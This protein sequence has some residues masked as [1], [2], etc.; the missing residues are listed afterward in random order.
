MDDAEAY[1]RHRSFP[2]HVADL[3]CTP[4]HTPLS[5]YLHAGV[6]LKPTAAFQRGTSTSLFY[7]TTRRETTKRACC[8]RWALQ[9]HARC[10][11]GHVRALLM[12]INSLLDGCFVF[13]AHPIP[14]AFVRCLSLHSEIPSAACGAVGA[15]GQ[16]RVRSPASRSTNTFHAP[17]GTT[18]TGLCCTASGSWTRL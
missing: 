9:Q 8:C 18:T 17:A 3:S 10:C 2:H 12:F 4:S 13:I 6:Q 14:M 16:H 7:S 5:S 15:S 11:P 1:Y